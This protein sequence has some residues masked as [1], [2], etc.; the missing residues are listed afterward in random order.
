GVVH[1]GMQLVPQIAPPAG[2]C[3]RGCA[4]EVIRFQHPHLDQHEMPPRQLADIIVHEAVDLFGII[5]NKGLTQYMNKEI[6]VLFEEFELHGE[7]PVE[8]MQGLL[9]T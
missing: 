6:L 3:S 7:F 9:W 5:Y 1:P 8:F 2:M 4:L